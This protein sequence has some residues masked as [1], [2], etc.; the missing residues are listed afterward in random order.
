[1][2][3]NVFDDP[4]ITAVGLLVEAYAGLSARFAA[5]FEEHGLSPVE[6][7]VLTRL[8]RSPNNQLRMTDLAA[9]T[10][11]ST[12]GVTRVVDRMERDGLIC[13]RACPSDRRSSFAVVTAAG[14]SRL[15]EILPGHLK[16]IEQWFTGQLDPAQLDGLLD[17][18]RRVRD[19]VHP[20]AT[21]GSTEP[22]GTAGY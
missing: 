19:A 4:R 6:F 2:D 1:M 11:L 3:Q 12:S 8:A 21:A 5:Q 9:Q 14:L 20:G 15:D 18:L 16:I 13:R 10:S 7:E 17:G 22:A